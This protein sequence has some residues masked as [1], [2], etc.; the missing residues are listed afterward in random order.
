MTSISETIVAIASPTHPAPRGI[1]RVSGED[2]AKI[3]ESLGV[4]GLAARGAQRRHVEI[5]LGSPLDRIPVD[6]LVWPNRR[7]YTGEPSM[8]LHTYGCLPILQSLVDS[9]IAAG[10]RAARPGEFTLRAFLAGRL[11]LTQ[12]EAVLG[13]I[14]A[15]HRGSLNHALRQLAGNLSRPLEQV[16]DTLLDLLADVEAGLD[17]VDEDIEFVSDAALVERLSAVAAQV[18]RIRQT[19]LERRESTAQIT[20]T[21]RGEPNIGKSRLINCLSRSEAAIVADVAGTTRDAVS[22]DLDHGGRR[23]RLLDTAGIETSGD[24]ISL[25]SQS[26]AEQATGEADVRI[27]CFDLSG[28][29]LPSSLEALRHHQQ[30]APEHRLDLWVGT[31][32]DACSESSRLSVPDHFSMLPPNDWYLTSS[33][34]GEGV[35]ELLQRIADAAEERQ[36]EETGSILG[37]AAR[38]SGSLLGAIQALRRAISLAERGEGHEFIADEL[39]LAIDRIGETTGAVY[40]DD[41]LDRVFGRF[42]IGK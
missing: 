33:V 12:A 20:V 27:W 8:E 34:T 24:A 37:T 10:A 35:A 6:I 40:T 3:L 16:R 11:D 39:R 19:L 30:R 29:D 21:L 9:I 15:E 4:R 17:F 38:C 41:I 42:C 2:V 32:L 28:P 18:D 26:Q 13:V 31:K 7:S 25:A 23:V 22:V 14:D 1:V 5:E 36:S